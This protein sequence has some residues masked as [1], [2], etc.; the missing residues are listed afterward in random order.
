MRFSRLALHRICFRLVCHGLWPT[1]S[2]ELSAVLM[3]ARVM[4]AERKTWQPVPPLPSL[5]GILVSTLPPLLS[6][7][8]S[9]EFPNEQHIPPS[10]YHCL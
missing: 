6:L 7:P 9:S 2:V 5:R 4:T 10:Q 3:G 8:T 1:V